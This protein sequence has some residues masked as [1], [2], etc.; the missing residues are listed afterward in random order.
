M[1]DADACFDEGMKHIG[2]SRHA[3][4]HSEYVGDLE[5]AVACFDRALA[6][7]PDHS[8][9]WSE[10][11]TALAI[12]GRHEEAASALAE[13]IRLRP[14][15]AE[16]W[17]ERAG[18]LQSL[19]RHDE[20]LVACDETLRL[21]PGDGDAMFLRAELLEALRRDAD[22]LAA[23]DAVL[24]LGDLRTM[25]FHGRTV[26]TLT[27]DFRRLKATIARA[28]V[29]ARLGRR[30]AAIDA[31]RKTIEEGVMREAIASDA[32]IA[33]LGVHEEA[34]A[35]YQAHVEGHRDNPQVWRNAGGAFIRAGRP[36]EALAAYE[37]A[38]RLAPDS[39]EGWY[40]KAESLFQAGRRVDAI[41]AYREALRIKPDYIPAK[42]RLDRVQME[43]GRGQSDERRPQ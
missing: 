2:L 11:G 21:R 36:G 13:A 14:G 9:A 19:A 8:G 39:P 23:W 1:S 20:A 12:L 24:G 33:A 28:G 41:A 40:G 6:L 5:D 22:A 15:V 30:D 7:K 17:L 29:V 4:Y 43:I 37:E 27:G 31:F 26:R 3:D 25:N 16:L 10:K 34:R 42:A 35:A 32:F 38:I 18:V